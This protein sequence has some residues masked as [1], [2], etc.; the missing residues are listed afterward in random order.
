VYDD[1][2][3]RAIAFESQWGPEGLVRDGRFAVLEG[4]RK[5]PAM[6][7]NTQFHLMDERGPR[8]RAERF[9]AECEYAITAEGNHGKKLMEVFNDPQYTRKFMKDWERFGGDFDPVSRL[10]GKYSGGASDKAFDRV[11]G[12]ALGRI[13]GKPSAKAQEE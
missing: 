10:F 1:L 12:S 13:P 5:M 2:K 11:A 6:H 3:A 4:G 8:E 7:G 9:I